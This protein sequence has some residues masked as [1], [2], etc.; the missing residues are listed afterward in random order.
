MPIESTWYPTTPLALRQIQPDLLAE[1]LVA[2]DSLTQRLHHLMNT[3]IEVE[4]QRQS[5]QLPLASERALLNIN[6]NVAVWTREVILLGK[7]EALIY[8]RSVFAK[9]T[10]EKTGKLLQKLGTRSLGD[11]LFTDPTRRR[12]PF[13][14]T[15]LQ[16][17]HYLLRRTNQILT[18]DIPTCW[19]RRSRFYY[20]AKP[21]LITEVF[22]PNLVAIIQHHKMINAIK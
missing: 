7:N 9:P 17:P 19:A 3:P 20:H 5:W 12:D 13:Q 21:L 18:K 8:A 10:L 11:F 4:I 14:I 2:P 15:R 6:S 22:L 16:R 1:W